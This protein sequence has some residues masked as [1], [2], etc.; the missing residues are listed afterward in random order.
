MDYLP[1][2][3]FIVI[4]GT[5]FVI[6]LGGWLFSFALQGSSVLLNPQKSTVSSVAKT[7]ELVLR[8]SDNDGLLDWEEVIWSTDPQKSDTDGDGTIDG[9]EVKNHRDP[10]NA[11]ANDIFGIL[12]ATSSDKG[13][14]QNNTLTESFN[15]DLNISYLTIKGLNEG[16]PL[17]EDQK[18]IISDS[19]SK[20][21]EDSALSS[22][23]I[24]KEK[25]IIISKTK[26]H[27]LYVNNLGAALTANFKGL[28]GSELDIIRGAGEDSEKRSTLDRYIEGYRKTILFLKQESVPPEY[29]YMHLE[30]LNIVGGL[31]YAVEE[32]RFFAT[33]PVRATLGIQ[34]YE[35]LALRLVDFLLLL[36][37][38]LDIDEIVFSA[39]EPGSLFYKYFDLQLKT[40]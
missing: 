13:S 17:T 22:S 35:P 1:S 27:R 5:A 9:E 20:N 19:L 34:L 14:S 37:N 40:Q 21:L 16:L 38:Q 33:D 25:D 36:Q 32:M 2:K 15:R 28:S 23:D 39:D 3:T 31:K 30:L 24:Y 12:D 11:S 26:D 4:V 6:V 8:D 10:L 7:E 18:A 29:A